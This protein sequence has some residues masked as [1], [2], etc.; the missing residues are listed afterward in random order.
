LKYHPLLGVRR[1]VVKILALM[2][3]TFVAPPLVYA[4]NTVEQQMARIEGPQVPDRQ[5]LDA[6][7][8]EGV[9]QRF[10][11]P[12]VSV[13]VIKDYQI[14]WAK[15]YGVADVKSG[16]AVTV[17]TQFQAA[18]ISKPITAMAVL[19]LMQANHFTL[20]DDV[21]TLLKSWHVPRNAATGESPVTLRSLLSHTSGAEDGF[22]FPGYAPGEPL[23]S[24]VQVLNGSPP[25]KLGPVLFARPPYSAYKYSGGGLEIIQQAITD[26]MGQPF[27]TTMQSQVLRPLNMLHSTYQQPL[28]EGETSNVALAHDE[29]GQRMDAPWHVY[30]EQAAAGL[31]TTPSDLARFAIE[32]QRAIRGPSGTILKQSSAREMTSPVGTG[33]FGVGLTLEIRG[34]GW[35]FSHGGSNWGFRN[36]LLAH[37][38]KGYG[39]VVMTNGEQ[40]ELVANEI[41][42]RVAAAYNWDSL[43]KEWIR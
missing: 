42:A 10:H 1:P 31:W 43:D 24:V 34:Q 39:V 18:S 5:G 16:R 20:D 7:T 30:P 32:V 21:N 27:E 12:G 33:P 41:E 6:L 28:P 29:S 22:G 38:R 4:E 9:M 37:I 36:D 14:H 35:Y 40:G 17:D 13:A 23:P 8:I 19:H 3:C 15:G 11:V 2:L 25:S 26:L